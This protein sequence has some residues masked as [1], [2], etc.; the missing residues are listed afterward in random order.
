MHAHFEAAA[1]VAAEISKVFRAPNELEFEKC[2]WPYCLMSK[3]RYAGRM[4]ASSPDKFDYIDVKGLA[5]VRRDFAP[6]VKESSNAVLDVLM[7]KQ[8][9]EL[10]V[11]T[12]RGYI[13]KVINEPPGCNM[14]P[15][16]MSKTLR[17][18]YK[19]ESQP[20]LYVAK[21]MAK[22]TGESFPS[23]SRVPYVY[24]IRDDETVLGTKSGQAEHPDWARAHNMELDKIYYIEN[25]LIKPLVNLLEAVDPRVED[26]LL[27][28]EV[29]E[30]LDALK[31]GEKVVVKEQKRLKMIK[32]Q[33]L[34]PI[35][36]FFKPISK[37]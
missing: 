17:G 8:D 11:Q 36:N 12:A 31:R 25:Q 24:C 13:E 33:R 6:I 27:R 2:Y 14:E 30:K 19:V 37:Q 34:Q 5:L 28:G 7:H 29:S 18:S 9:A 22:R 3:K 16:I 21:N 20:H 32:D 4:F 15:Y 10:A 23:G 26:R 35:S 1:R